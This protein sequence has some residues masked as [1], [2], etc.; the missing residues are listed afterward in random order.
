MWRS[1]WSRAKAHHGL[2]EAL[3]GFSV[4]DIA[5]FGLGYVGAVTLAALADMQH[6]MIGVDANPTKVDMINEGRSPVIEDGLEELIRA[7]VNA[8]R[9]AATED[10][11]E[12]VK[13]AEVSIVCVG[14][15]SHQNGSLAL[16]QVERV[17]RQ[18][19]ASL[20]G[21]SRR[22]TVMFRS[23][24]LP[25]SMN[26]V[27]IPALE[28]SSGLR[29]GDD[30]GVCFNPEFLR[31]GSSIRDFLNPPLTLIG[32]DDPS[33]A[34]VVEKLYVD[35]PCDTIVVSIPVAEMVKYAS[36]AFHALKV[37]YANE[38]GAIC[39]SLGVDSHEVM[40][41][42]KRDTKLNISPAYLTPGFAFGGSCLP[43]D[44]RALTY[45]S[46]TLDLS[47]PL[48]DSIMTSN[49]HQVDRA[50][51]MIRSAG[52]KSVGI[53]GISFKAGTDDLRESPMV[54]LVERLIGKGYDVLVYDRSV[55]LA[56]LH[57][58]NREYI[59]REIP[60]IAS[61]MCDDLERLVRESTVLVIG[62][63]DPDF[64]RI[65]TFSESHH[66]VVDLVRIVTRSELIDGYD[67][68]AW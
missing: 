19:G 30:F 7:G 25:G 65:A 11:V 1:R 63:S 42:F 52:S 23:T 54:E 48:L 58:A 28:E 34:N 57:G 64:G 47:T 16:E 26:N 32:V 51:E 18:I 41:V 46:K 14:T 35:L 5:V 4:T 60:H 36:N 45:L 59:Q 53:L 67:G 8:D 68:I 40:D 39:K 17:A 3:E 62:N 21:M 38:L 15:P 6:R 44:L 20:P 49:D 37:A 43:K 56:N 22:H 24:M 29:A 12:A 61:I 50:F 13:T 33:S 9:I 55:S 66:T 2:P 31:E 10:A 27:V